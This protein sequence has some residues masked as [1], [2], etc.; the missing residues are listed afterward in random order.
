MTYVCPAKT[1]L[2]SA[3]TRLRISSTFWVSP[4]AAALTSSSCTSPVTWVS[5]N[6]FS[7]A[8]KFSIKRRAYSS[9]FSYRFA[10]LGWTMW[11]SV[12]FTAV[13][14]SW[15][16]TIRGNFRY[17]RRV[18][19]P[20]RATHFHFQIVIVINLLNPANFSKSLCEINK[21]ITHENTKKTCFTLTISILRNRMLNLWKSTYDN[22]VIKLPP[23]PT[24]VL[25]LQI[26]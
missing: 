20:R 1:P 2:T 3:S 5:N 14:G 16:R 17:G 19:R 18:V 22:N 7:R 9:S 12:I 23:P 13:T 25:W 24:L 8:L 4:L 21:T 26:T 6:F 10:P 15:Q 11:S